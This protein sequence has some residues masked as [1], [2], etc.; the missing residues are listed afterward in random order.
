[1]SCEADI[2]N[3]IKDISFDLDK[4]I[5][6]NLSTFFAKVETDIS[7]VKTFKLLLLNL[8][9]YKELQQNFNDLQIKYNELKEKNIQ[10]QIE[11][12]DKKKYNE[13]STQTNTQ[14]DKIEED[15]HDIEE[16]GE[17]NDVDEEEG[18]E[19]DVDEEEGEQDNVDEKECEQDDA[20]EE[21][22]EEDDVDEEEGE[23]DDADEE[24]GEE[25]D[26]V[27]EEGGEDDADEEEGEE[28]D[29][30]EE[31][32]GEDD[33]DEEEEELEPVT[34]NNI[35]YYQNML[36]NDIY[37]CTDNEEIGEYLGKLFNGKIKK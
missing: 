17:E 18:E 11:D 19:N 23:E 31:E 32:G 21:E 14:N 29:T 16:E 24:E 5:K 28:D 12:I 22:G 9:E 8:P 2:N 20:D 35:N 30:D 26:T 7:L 6:S 37:E 27:E 25:D 33:A 36:T 3:I 13:I 4:S 34:I 10:I 15:D 1:M